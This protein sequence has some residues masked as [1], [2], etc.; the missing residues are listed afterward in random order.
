[1]VPHLPLARA[2]ALLVL[3]AA[4]QAGPERSGASASASGSGATAQTLASGDVAPPPAHAAHAPAASDGSPTMTVY[5]S[6]TCGC[7]R[8]WVDHMKKAGFR[9]VSIDT[10]DMNAVKHEHGVTNDIGSCHTATVGGYVIEGHVPAADVKRLLAERP[11]ITGLAVPGMPVGSPGM[12][13]IYSEKYNVV[14][15]DRTGGRSVFATH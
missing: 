3:T 5:K 9:V 15:F 2:V 10:S 6:P 8:A 13:G 14:A 4:C 12:E 11:S 7:C 1:M